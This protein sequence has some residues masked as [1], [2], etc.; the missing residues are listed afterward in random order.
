MSTRDGRITI[1]EL[2]GLVEAEQ[3]DTV[4]VGFSDLYGRL[5]GK[6]LEAG[7]FCESAEDG[8]HGLSLIHI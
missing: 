5:M 6:R 7:F 1:E 3:I 4:V 8:T 2:R